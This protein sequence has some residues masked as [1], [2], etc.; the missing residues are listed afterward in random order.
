MTGDPTTNEG[1]APF[2]VAAGVTQNL[3]TD[4]SELL[5]VVTRQFRSARERAIAHS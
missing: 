3:I 2:L 1:T 4:Q 5:D